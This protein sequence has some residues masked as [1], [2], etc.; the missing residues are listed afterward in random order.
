MDVT[1]ST[2]D[3]LQQ[4]GISKRRIQHCPTHGEQEVYDWKIAGAWRKSVCPVCLEQCQ[5]EQAQQHDRNL[6][7]EW[8][9][10]QQVKALSLI[11]ISE[12][13]RP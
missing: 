9:Q 5:R 10:E 12:P 11:H 7:R 6:Q 4:L 2:R 8:A 13:T 3:V 1:Q